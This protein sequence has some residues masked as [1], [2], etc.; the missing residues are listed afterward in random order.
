MS[1]EVRATNAKWITQFYE[2]FYLP[3]I[4]N[5]SIIHLRSTKYTD[6]QLAAA[7]GDTIP[8]QVIYQYMQN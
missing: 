5:D 4:L 3:N 6:N 1:H 7:V 2:Q 8:A